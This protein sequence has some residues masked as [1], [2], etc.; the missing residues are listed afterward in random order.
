[1]QLLHFDNIIHLLRELKGRYASY[2]ILKKGAGANG[3]IQ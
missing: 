2:R 1:M 3:Y